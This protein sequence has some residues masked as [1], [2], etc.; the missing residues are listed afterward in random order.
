ML[1]ALIFVT[2]IFLGFFAGRIWPAARGGAGSRTEDDGE[3]KVAEQL[4][5]LLPVVRASLEESV[6]VTEEVV[7]RAAGAVEKVTARVRQ[8]LATVDAVLRSWEESRGQR[9]EVFYRVFHKLEEGLSLLRERMEV[10]EYIYKAI[11][12]LEQKARDEKLF[13]I[14]NELEEISARIRLVAL[15]AAIEAARVGEAGRGFAV[16]AGEVQRLAGQS[17]KAVQ[18]VSQFGHLLLK[19]IRE[20]ITDMENSATALKAAADGL[21]DSRKEAGNLAAM[22]RQWDET[23]EEDAARIAGELKAIDRHLDDGITAF[24]FQDAVAQQIS[25]V[26]DILLRVEKLL[27]GGEDGKKIDKID[28]LKELEEMYTMES[29]RA[30]HRRVLQPEAGAGGG[31]G[32][33]GNVE[34]F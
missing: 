16:V 33:S 8:G 25:H 11:Y 2:G 13:G 22:H 20:K 30:T 7:L 10:V 29:E 32:E 4:L 12:E 19:D 17:G 21:A 3:I 9:E 28:I 5:K 14:L 6:R 26:R 24:Q 34:F 31:T 27:A 18:S 23:L 15:N 1:F